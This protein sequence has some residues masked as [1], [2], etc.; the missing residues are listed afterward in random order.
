MT[1]FAGSK[2]D[3]L[4]QNYLNME[5]VQ[6]TGFLTGEIGARLANDPNGTI[7]HNRTLNKLQV[8]L[9]GILE[10]IALT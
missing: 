3:V 8:K 5:T 9:N 2:K 6:L 7:Y 4:D 10:T 1:I